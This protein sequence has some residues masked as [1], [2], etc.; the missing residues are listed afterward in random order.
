MTT[1]SVALSVLLVGAYANPLLADDPETVRM[2]DRE[3][4]IWPAEDLTERGFEV[5]QIPRDKN[6]AW[7]YIEA[8]NAYVDLPAEIADAFDYA[9]KNAWPQ[10]QTK[11]E[12]YLK[13]PKNRLALDKVRQGARM[14]RCQMPY[15]GDPNQSVISLLLPS[16]SGIRFLSKLHAVE[17]RWL[18]SQGRP[19]E[20]LDKYLLTMRMGEHIGQ[21]ITLIEALV[22][23]AIW[24]TADRAMTDA[25]LRRPLSLDQLER[26]QRQLNE[27][28]ARLP[29][30]TR[31]LRGETTF[32]PALVDELC[33]RPLRIPTNVMSL[34]N[35]E[36][37]DW[38][39][40]VDGNANPQDGWGKLELRV[41]QLFFPDRSIKKHMFDYYDLVLELAHRGP[42]RGAELEFDENEYIQNKIPKW[43]LFSR[44]FLPSLSRATALGVRIKATLALTRT[45]VA[46]RIHTLQNKGE[47]P[48]SL[49]EIEGKL[50]E[51][52]TIDPFSDEPLRYVRTADGW[53]LYSVGLNLIDDG[54]E[55]GR[56]WDGLDIARQYPPPPVKPFT[57][58][59]DKE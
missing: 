25:I 50:P 30:T 53:L 13:D 27:R 16:L 45:M 47:P 1:R 34:F 49:Y 15:F 31:G 20:A 11:L 8:V 44:M 2:R 46:I 23:I 55:N 12:K 21:G 19:V 9:I 41:G 17:G 6:A 35:I 7:V 59:G 54:G 37:G 48:E 28:T 38:I 3:F 57:P 36:E 24:N 42:R 4:T 51:G 5:P 52:A 22:G 33:S 43:D 29:S 58:S 32:G 14:D 18:E 39:G 56:F 40:P 10:G 26:L